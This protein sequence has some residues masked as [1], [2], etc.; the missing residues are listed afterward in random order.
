[1]PVQPSIAYLDHAATTPLRP[2]A[3]AAMEPWLG[4][5]FGNPSG[6]HRVARAARQPN[7]VIFTGGGTEADN[8]VVLGAAGAVVASAIEH[9]AVLEPLA[10]VG[11]STVPVDRRGVVDLD[12]LSAA[13]RSRSDVALVSVM[14]AN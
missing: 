10:R 8:L 9:H 12:A 4:S 7:E 13:L 11:G 2:E 3:R 1:M 6:A 5:S 14:T